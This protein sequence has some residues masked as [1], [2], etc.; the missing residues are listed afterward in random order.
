MASA[1]IRFAKSM[2]MQQFLKACGATGP[3][4]LAVE[5]R[6]H[7]VE[8]WSR[9]QPFALIG[10]D[11]A[12]DL[13]LEHPHVHA[14]HVYVQ[15]ISGE[16]YWVNLENTVEVPA[17]S[18]IAHSGWLDRD[19]KIYVGP[20]VVSVDSRRR[21][22]LVRDPAR[23]VRPDPFAS[24]SRVPGGLPNLVMEFHPDSARPIRW[25]MK[26]LLTLVGS[27]AR[28]H[29]RLAC[30]GVSP[31]HCSFVRTSDGVW[32]VNLLGD[33]GV[34]LNGEGVRAARL[35]DGDQL[36]IGEV[37]IRTF[38]DAP[39]VTNGAVGLI[40]HRETG[41]KTFQTYPSAS[42]RE[43]VA[44][45]PKAARGPLGRTGGRRLVERNPGEGELSTSLLT[46][47][48][49]QFG[50]MQQEF[51]SQFQQTTLITL[52]AIGALH[53]DQTRELF[54]K[55]AALHGAK[56]SLQAF[57]ARLA[58]GFAAGQGQPGLYAGDLNQINE[59]IKNGDLK[60][61]GSSLQNAPAA[62]ALLGDPRHPGPGRDETDDLRAKMRSV[63]DQA[64]GSGVNIHEWLVDRIGVLEGEQRTGWKR[65][66]DLVL[67]R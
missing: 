42:S 40:D 60:S 7:F 35:N 9:P 4:E 62:G 53:R 21:P 34:T 56:E 14:F 20:Y 19:Q 28:C 22:V 5:D 33:V 67:R 12:T 46:L 57:M 15:V 10:R 3:L 30:R 23:D 41:I 59:A 32:V 54:E 8:H 24:H 13:R 38:L 2:I 25:R 39:A 51:L 55:L 47:V 27:A 11:L 31:F 18:C 26:Q 29:V 65:I 49:D 50:Q 52:Q 36:R 58:T 45:R 6:G 61:L 16:V 37:S 64:N 43:L 63:V 44:G 17:A 48:L 66:L 1:S